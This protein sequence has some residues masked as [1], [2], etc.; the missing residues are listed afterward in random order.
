MNGNK[1]IIDA[2][3][4][5]IYNKKI[6]SS[7]FLIKS[8]IDPCYFLKSIKNTE[9]IKHM[10]NAHLEDGVAL[11]KFIFWMKNLKN[12][13]INE[14]QAQK[15]LELFRKKNKNYLYP[16]F[17]TIAGTGSNGAIVHYKANKKTNKIIKKNHLFLCDSGGQYSYGTT[18]VTRTICF[19]KQTK[20]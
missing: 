19:N 16:S 9:E 6:I 5:S 17:D 7:K 3:T 12:K 13:K 15:K 20:P 1:F 2:K 10:K 4:C 14:I 8:E 11:T 18:D